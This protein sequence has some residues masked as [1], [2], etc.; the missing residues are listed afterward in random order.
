MEI[1]SPISN[2]RGS[3]GLS[4]TGARAPVFFWACTGSESRRAVTNKVIRMP[5][6]VTGEAEAARALWGEINSRRAD[7]Y[8][9]RSPHT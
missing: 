8:I 3:L 7:D 5:R 4:V 6:R 2:T 1:E 9:S